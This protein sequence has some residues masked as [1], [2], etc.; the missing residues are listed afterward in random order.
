MA[1]YGPSR[2]LAL[3]HHNRYRG[4][5]KIKVYD[6]DVNT[7]IRVKLCR[8]FGSCEHDKVIP[9]SKEI[10]IRIKDFDLVVSFVVEKK[11]WLWWWKPLYITSGL[12]L[13]A[14]ING[15]RLMFPTTVNKVVHVKIIKS[16]IHI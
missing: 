9:A 12:H 1:P 3:Y 11:T 8:R 2:Y 5:V 4:N 16:R 10:E 6:L 14:V 15:E 13:K 7:R